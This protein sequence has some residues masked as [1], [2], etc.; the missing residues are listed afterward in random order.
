MKT[1]EL[2]YIVTSY[3]YDKFLNE[4]LASLCKQWTEKNPFNVLV[5]DD[6]SV[7]DSI[8]IINSYSKKYN[9]VSLL[10]HPGNK[11]KGLIESMRLAIATVET[12]WV[13]FLESDDFSKAGSV[14][15][16]LKKTGEGAGIIFCNIEPVGLKNDDSNWFQS[17]VPR[18]CKKMLDLGAN[19]QPVNLDFLILTE[20]LIPTFSCAAVK[21]KLLK[22][23]DFNSPVPE[24]IDWYL[25]IQICQK[26]KVSFIAEKQVFWR[27]HSDSLNRKKS[28]FQYFRK[29]RLFRKGVRRLL[30]QSETDH[31]CYKIAYLYLP[32]FVPLSIRFFKMSRFSGYRSVFNKLIGRLRK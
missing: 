17:Y 3:N 1:P 12:P 8:N 22:E 25:W 24:W 26:T 21:T 18:I 15:R 32:S 10:T 2:T 5:V 6:G 7:D 20:N 4:N 19:V 16:L 13:A 27:Q 29:Y 14:E 28:I 31:K 23:A 9:F 11:N 30:T